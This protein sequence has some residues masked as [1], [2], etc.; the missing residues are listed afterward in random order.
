MGHLLG[1]AG[2]F[3]GIQKVITRFYAGESKRLETQPDGTM[4][5]LREN[6]ERLAGVI[7]R[8]QRGRYRF[9]RE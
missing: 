6:G 4:H 1:S 2:S 9:E 5:V 7:V 8:F 3:D